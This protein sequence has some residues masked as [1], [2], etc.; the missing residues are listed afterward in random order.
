VRY[1]IGINLMND[2]REVFAAARRP[3]AHTHGKR[4]VAVIGPFRNVRAALWTRDNPN[5]RPTY[6]CGADLGKVCKSRPQ[7]A[8]HKTTTRLYSATTRGPKEERPHD[9][10]DDVIEQVGGLPRK[11]RS[12]DARKTAK[13]DAAGIWAGYAEAVAAGVLA[14]I[15]PGRTRPDEIA[16]VLGLNTAED[17]WLALADAARARRGDRASLTREEQLLERDAQ[18]AEEFSRAALCQVGRASSRASQPVKAGELN[19]GETFTVDGEKFEVEYVDPETEDVIV[20]DGVRFGKQTLLENA[21]L[22]PDPGSLSRPSTPEM[23]S[24]GQAP[25]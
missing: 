17:M 22:C 14:L 9:V 5:A 13:R 21:V 23:A 18:S 11:P 10:I 7:P 2:A 24:L 4:Y 25:F 15:P 20:R 16:D 8:A 6:L 3:T 19:V 1:Y 12:G